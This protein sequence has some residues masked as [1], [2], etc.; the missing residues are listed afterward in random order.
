MNNND[1]LRDRPPGM[2]SWMLVCALFAG[3]LLALVVGVLLQ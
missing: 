3:F 2:P 1:P